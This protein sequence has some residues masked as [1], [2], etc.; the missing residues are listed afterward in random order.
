MSPKKPKTL[1]RQEKAKPKGRYATHFLALLAERGWTKEQFS[2]KSGIP[3]ATIRKWL[4]AESMPSD[5]E[6]LESIA[7]AFNTPQHPLTDYRLV[8]PPPK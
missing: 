4:R 7:A 6:T 2:D 5:V 1:N 3:D 8:L